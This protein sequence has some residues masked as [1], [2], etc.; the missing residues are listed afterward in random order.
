LADRPQPSHPLL[1]IVPPSSSQRHAAL[2]VSVLLLAGFLATLPFAHIAWWRI[3]GFILIQQALLF[4]NDLITAALLFGQYSIHRTRAVCVLAGGYLFTALIVIPHALSFPGV[5]SD[6]GLLGGGPQSAAWLYIG[7]HTVL[8][9]TVIVFALRR[10]DENSWDDSRGASANEIVS[11]V[12]M[13]VIV[14]VIL[15][16]LVIVGHAWL[17]RIIE[18]GNFTTETRVAVGIVLV[19]P[20]AAIL[21]LARRQ[22]KAILDVWLM[23][24][25]FAWLC[26]IAL[27]AFVS[28]GRYDVGWYSGRVFDWLASLLILLMLLSETVVLYARVARATAIELRQRDRRLKEVQAV[29]LHQSRA[30]ELGQNVS[31]LIHEVG[32]PLFSVMNYL[33]VST[34]LLDAGDTDRL[35]LTLQRS[36]EQAARAAEI[37]RHLRDFIA[38]HES[39]NQSENLLKILRRAVRLALAGSGLDPA[40][41]EIQCIDTASVFCDRVQIEQVLFNLVRNAIEAMTDSARRAVT[42]SVKFIDDNMIEVSVA[43]TGGGLA[44]DVRRRLFE[45]FVTTKANGL[46]VGLSICRA[47][48]EAHG[49]RLR[50]DDNP[51]GGTI[52]CFTL[53]QSPVP[54]EAGDTAA[55]L[56]SRAARF[57]SSNRPRSVGDAVVGSSNE[58]AIKP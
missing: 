52:F 27:G 5:F 13:A 17:P 56:G 10:D 46:G 26:T 6:T 40:T 58:I 4:S 54:R 19:L 23:V 11:A 24:V 42:I 55:Q 25:M 43:D 15:T 44:P 36:A 12:L 47:I 8:P 49:G 53:P 48:I 31:S 2:A 9:V 1:S 29:L 30:N 18:N 16:F 39:Q 14:V 45:P 41:V 34:K 22:P 33:A 51:G 37:I 7:W 28:G 50:A 21:V 3:P 35:K 38:R 20:L 32:Q 57:L